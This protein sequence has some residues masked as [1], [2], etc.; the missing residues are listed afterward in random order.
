MEPASSSYNIFAAT[1]KQ[2]TVL[3]R[4]TS[5]QLM[6]V[7][8][9][10]FSLMKDDEDISR[11]DA[12]LDKIGALNSLLRKSSE[13]TYCSLIDSF[14]SYFSDCLKEVFEKDSRVLAIADK[15]YKA[16]D[17]IQARDIKDIYTIITDDL[18]HNLNMKGF[19]DLM[20]TLHQKIGIHAFEEDEM[21]YITEHIERRNLIVHNRG[22]VD[23]RFALKIEK[24]KGDSVDVGVGLRV[25]PDSIDELAEKLSSYALKFDKV[26]SKKYSL[27]QHAVE[28]N[29]S[30]K[31]YEA[32][33]SEV[34]SKASAQAI[35][36]I[37]RTQSSDSEE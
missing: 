8:I 23:K 26:M 19:E 22:R 36:F 27:T 30:Q 13:Q 17:F 21:K 4:V 9:E 14:L 32:I 12:L 34:R 20:K 16:V 5:L 33:L 25:T 37:N 10:D 31:G 18:V 29:R 6:S 35:E 15:A 28:N 24:I 7:Y 11:V 3:H 2:C 1:V